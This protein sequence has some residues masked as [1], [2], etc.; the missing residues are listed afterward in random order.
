[1]TSLVVA[2]ANYEHCCSSDNVFVWLWKH[3]KEI[4]MHFTG[5]KLI[6]DAYKPFPVMQFNLLN[7]NKLQQITLVLM[8]LGCSM[9]HYSHFSL[10]ILCHPRC[11]RVMCVAENPMLNVLVWFLHNPRENPKLN[12]EKKAIHCQG[13]LSMFPRIKLYVYVCSGTFP[14]GFA[15][16]CK[17][18]T[19][20]MEY[21]IRSC[22]VYVCPDETVVVMRPEPQTFT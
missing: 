11:H 16:A 3:I 1:M 9:P 22:S 15:F 2:A 13:Q 6:F 12:D 14:C 10:F 5:R 21:S 7:V 4:C 17:Y 19:K 8:R 20:P 18:P